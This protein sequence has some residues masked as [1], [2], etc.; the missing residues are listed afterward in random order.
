MVQRDALIES[1]ATAVPT[2]LDELN[3]AQQ[4][5]QQEQP[6]RADLNTCGHPSTEHA[7]AID[8]CGSVGRVSGGSPSKKKLPARLGVKSVFLVSRLAGNLLMS[9]HGPRT[10]LT[11]LHL[12]LRR[13]SKPVFGCAHMTTAR[14]PACRSD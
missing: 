10:R 13:G 14:A 11:R 4:L 8:R 7:C 3:Q 6:A 9:V 12:N 2:A 1:V 5:I